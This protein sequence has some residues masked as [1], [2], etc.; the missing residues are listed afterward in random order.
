[1][2]IDFTSNHHVV[3]VALSVKKLPGVHALH[4]LEFMEIT[5]KD[6]AKNI[7]DDAKLRAAKKGIKVIP[8]YLGGEPGFEITR[9]AN[10]S[11]Y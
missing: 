7:L 6:E 3:I 5:S 9:F 2:A 4:P 8:K 11:K 10:S 1:M